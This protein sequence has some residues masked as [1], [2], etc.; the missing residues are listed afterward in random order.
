[1]KT[2]LEKLKNENYVLRKEAKDSKIQKE[3]ISNM[4]SELVQKKEL[5]VQDLAKLK[6]EYSQMMEQDK[7]RAKLEQISRSATKK[8]VQEDPIIPQQMV[9]MENIQT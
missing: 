5:L 6:S 9:T 7:V 2:I 4:N 8:K 1:M 3:E